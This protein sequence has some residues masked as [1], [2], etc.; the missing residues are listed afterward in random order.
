[1]LLPILLTSIFCYFL[2]RLS[3]EAD[4][5]EAFGRRMEAQVE[6]LR[7]QLSERASELDSAQRR[8]SQLEK[9]L[10]ETSLSNEN[11]RSEVARLTAQADVTQSQLREARSQANWVDADLSNVHQVCGR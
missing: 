5:A 10:V 9:D 11:Y 2:R 8:L 1:M 3:E 7:M 6:S 4:S